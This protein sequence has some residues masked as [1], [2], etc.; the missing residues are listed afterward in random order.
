MD[1]LTHGLLGLAIGALRRPTRALPKGQWSPTD[2]AVLFASALAAELPDLDGLWPRENEVLGAI[3]VH[4]GLSHSLLLSPGW[5]LLA[6]WLATRLFRGARLGPPLAFAWA[7]VLFGHLAADAWTGWGTRLL[8]PF[9][10]ARLSWDWMMVVDPLFTAPL[11]LG[12]L[13]ALLFRRRWR[14]ALLTGLLLSGAYLASRV[15]IRTGLERRVARSDGS[16]RAVTVFPDWLGLT[17]WRFVAERPKEWV[18]G[19]VALLGPPLA[20][21]KHPRSP[22]LP[23]RLLANPTVREAAQWARFPLVTWDQ[24]ADGSSTVRVVELRYHLWGEPTLA[25][26]VEL[27]PGGAVTRAALERPHDPRALLRRWRAG[28]PK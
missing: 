17:R 16:F 19:S 9:S 18:A 27:G 13:A 23:E 28:P 20:H 5:A 11:I 25:M 6:A 8:L 7:A 12:A 15:V 24:T 4:R 22:P 14:L 3:E 21:A 10:A 2:K 1:N 26:E